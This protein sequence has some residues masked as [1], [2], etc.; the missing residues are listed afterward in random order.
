MNLLA[1]MSRFSPKPPGARAGGNT[2]PARPRAQHRTRSALL[3]A[4]SLVVLGAGAPALASCEDSQEAARSPFTGEPAEIGPVLSVKL[5][6]ARQARPHTG[7]QH[8]DLVY[9]SPVE[10]GLSRL[11]AVYSATLPERVGP[12]RSVRESD[13]DLLP[14]FGEPALA[15]SG[16]RSALLPV[17]EEAPIHPVTPESAGSAFLRGGDRPAPHN[18]YVRPAEA[19][20]AAPGTTDA[21]DIGFRFG[22]A[23]DGGTPTASHTVEYRSASFTFQWADGPGRWMVD[24]DGQ[25]ARD[26]TGSRL[27]AA[28]VVVQYTDIEP[29][30]F[31]ETPFVET[32][33]SGSALVLRD[34]EAHSAEW[35]RTTAEGGT[36]FTDQDG[37]RLHFAP[38]QVWVVYAPADAAP[39]TAP[40]TA[41]EAATEAG[42]EAG[43]EAPDRS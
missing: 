33:G 30:Q 5:D 14:T 9:A 19:L 38:G 16:A 10:G 36:V 37:E 20:A 42:T 39:A 12:V 21:R 29:S 31:P 35:Q 25:A 26:E 34:G 8:A 23:P 1:R 17:I 3:L 15:Y 28:T 43:T 22:P 40:D 4:V 6:N 2:R 11:M 32:V 24:M 13:L 18:L 7:L 41:T 27:R